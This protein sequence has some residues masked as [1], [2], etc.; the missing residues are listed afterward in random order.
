[1]RGKDTSVPVRLARRE[2][3]R[4]KQLAEAERE[5][6]LAE[7]TYAGKQRLRQPYIEARSQLPTLLRAGNAPPSADSIPPSTVGGLQLPLRAPIS[8]VVTAVKV[9]EGEFV[10]AAR[11]LFT[12]MNLD[13]LWVEAKTS[14][15]DLERATAAKAAQLTVAAFPGRSFSLV[16]PHAR[17]IDVAPVIDP[18]T[19]TITLRYELANLDRAL[20]VGMF[21]EV[22]IE[23]GRATNVLAVPDSAVVDE[24]GRPI[25]YVQLAGQTYE[26]RDVELGLRS[27]GFVEIK[28][29]LAEGERAVVRGAYSVRLSSLSGTIPEHGHAH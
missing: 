15:Y 24:D 5:L 10:D 7:A 2:S 20:R 14:E 8:G 18:A 1:L 13:R 26:R 4:K 27:A 29:G 9:V 25:V 6:R 23:I 21:G 28:R 22:A 16:E 11:P 3:P 12:I 17:L 19:R